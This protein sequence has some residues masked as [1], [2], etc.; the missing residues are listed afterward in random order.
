MHITSR[1]GNHSLSRLSLI[2]PLPINQILDDE[3]LSNPVGSSAFEDFL[4]LL[5]EKVELKG[6]KRYR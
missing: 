2:R 3:I 5:G 6:W 4:S 1:Q